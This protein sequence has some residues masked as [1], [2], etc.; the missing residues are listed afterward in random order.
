MAIKFLEILLLIIAIITFFAHNDGSPA[1][2]ASVLVPCLINAIVFL[3]VYV[4][5][6]TQ[7]RTTPVELALYSYS[8]IGL[9]ISSILLMVR[10]DPG[11]LIASGIFCL[12]LSGIYGVEVY[13][14]YVAL[15]NR[16]P[17][18]TNV[19]T[20][21]PP[22]QQP[23]VISTPVLD[24]QP[25]APPS[26]VPRA[27]TVDLGPGQGTSLGPDT[28]SQ[29]GPGNVYNTNPVYPATMNYPPYPVPDTDTLKGPAP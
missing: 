29:Q 25:G 11:N 16:P 1:Y 5:G 8:V 13:F 23:V 6:Y 26:L 3:A 17:Q 9:F 27:D 28:Q 15:V 19:V 7:L 2:V 12:F 24:V 20:V 14:S 10:A 21:P 4:L 22:H 18:P